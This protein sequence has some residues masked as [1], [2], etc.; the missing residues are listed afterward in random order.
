[1]ARVPL[2]ESEAL[3][4]E[5][6][7]VSEYFR[8]RGRELPELYRVLANAPR[9]LLAWTDFAWP[10]RNEAALPRG[11]RELAIMRVAQL[12][13]ADA[14]WGSHAPMALHYGIDQDQ[15]DELERWPA[16][17]RFDASQRE[18][19]AFTDELTSGLAVDDETFSVL[20]QRWSP[21]ELVELTLT[22]A[23]YSCV[24]RVLLALEIEGG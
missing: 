19:L 7:P 20:A 4:P 15:L 9:L 11:L 6:E 10:L 13:G 2:V 1:M 8:A 24:S 3:G 12:T 17:E 21:G 16:S 14:E 5:L 22:V 18:V 23:F